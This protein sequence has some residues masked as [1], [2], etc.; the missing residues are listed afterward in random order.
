[1][2]RKKPRDEAFCTELCAVTIASLNMGMLL[3]IF[4]QALTKWINS[5]LSIVKPAQER[6]LSVDRNVKRR[7]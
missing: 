4:L 2:R 6:L 5:R 1:M 7:S 3:V